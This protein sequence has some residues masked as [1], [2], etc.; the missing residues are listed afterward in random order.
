MAVNEH[1]HNLGLVQKAQNWLPLELSERQ[2]EMRKTIC[3]LLC[4]K[5]PERQKAWLL[6]GEPGSLTSTRNIH[7]Q[8][9]MLCIW[10]DQ[11]SMVYHQS[12]T[13]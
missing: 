5:N 1:L 10:W 2:L 13:R 4:Y 12:E 7:A 6:P 8:K 3:E 9:V 11:E